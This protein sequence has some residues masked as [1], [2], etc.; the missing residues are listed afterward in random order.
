MA[1]APTGREVWC[2]T[3]FPSRLSKRRGG[4]THQR[5]DLWCVS[6]TGG[7]RQ[8]VSGWAIRF[9]ASASRASKNCTEVEEAALACPNLDPSDVQ[10]VEVAKLGPEPDLVDLFLAKDIDQ[11]GAKV[12]VIDHPNRHLQIRLAFYFV[13]KGVK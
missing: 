7:R 1:G 13:G 5:R 12:G 9:S 10:G 8:G 11:K 2:R 4:A 3:R 6:R